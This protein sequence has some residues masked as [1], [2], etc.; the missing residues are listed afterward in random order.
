MR[1]MIGRI[2]EKEPS[3]VTI[4]S[5]ADGATALACGIMPIIDE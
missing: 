5:R 1:L 3:L 2:I 4:F